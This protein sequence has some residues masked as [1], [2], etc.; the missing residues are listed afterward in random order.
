MLD[1]SYVSP[2]RAPPLV[3]RLMLGGKKRVSAVNTIEAY[4]QPKTISFSPRHSLASALLCIIAER[5][6][7]KTEADEP[8]RRFDRVAAEGWLARTRT[9]GYALRNDRTPQYQPAEEQFCSAEVEPVSKAALLVNCCCRKRDLLGF[10][11]PRVQVQAT[12]KHSRT[13]CGPSRLRAEH[14]SEVPLRRTEL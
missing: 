3:A 13:A 10:T 2:H 1:F 6:E 12:R 7:P 8:A 11:A 9:L 5:F 14:A 4:A